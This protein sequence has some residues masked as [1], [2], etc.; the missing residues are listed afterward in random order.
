MCAFCS[1]CG[2]ISSYSPEPIVIKTKLLVTET[3][4]I[5]TAT[6]FIEIA[7]TLQII[8]EP[9]IEAV[10]EEINEKV[11]D[12]ICENCLFPRA[13][14]NK[15]DI[16]Y[17]GT[18]VKFAIALDSTI[19]NDRELGI[20]DF[21]FD[22]ENHPNGD[23]LFA[24]VFLKMHYGGF[25]NDNIG[26]GVSF[27][28]YVEMVKNGKGQ[29]TTIGMTD[30]EG[31]TNQEGRTY[32]Q[33][34]VDPSKRINFIISKKS[35]T[36]F[37]S[38]YESLWIANNSE[39]GELHIRVS[40]PYISNLYIAKRDG[41]FNKFWGLSILRSIFYSMAAVVSDENILNSNNNKAIGDLVFGGDKWWGIL[42]PVTGLE[43]KDDFPII[44]IEGWN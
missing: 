7:P 19:V 42:D 20:K 29:Y 41:E 43:N 14:E 9:I 17:N 26:S 2:L 11:E 32:R 24:E 40:A 23:I 25:L 30:G 39:S 38:H 16:D 37:I 27:E 1:S 15:Y 22:K 31:L 3:I 34:V 6:P 28:N 12:T 36:L 5:L 44:T 21:W 4:P 35:N 18:T 10:N 8:E 13:I 33:L